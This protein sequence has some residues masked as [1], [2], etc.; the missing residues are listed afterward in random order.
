MRRLRKPDRIRL[1]SLPL[2]LRVPCAKTIKPR[3][4]SSSSVERLCGDPGLVYLVSDRRQLGFEFSSPFV[5]VV[6]CPRH[7]DMAIAHGKTVKLCPGAVQFR[8]LKETLKNEAL[9][10]SSPRA[11]D[12]RDLRRA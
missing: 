3:C 7:R 2:W 4:F 5:K 6:M 11:G 8:H 9:A 12:P 1:R 10:M